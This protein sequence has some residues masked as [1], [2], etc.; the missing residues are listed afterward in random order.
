MQRARTSS[1]KKLS[2]A[3]FTAKAP[4]F[5]IVFR[6]LYFSTT[7]S[8]GKSFVLLITADSSAGPFVLFVGGRSIGEV[9]DPI[10]DRGA[11]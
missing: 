3:S 9:M 11:A 7:V 5:P 1:P 2:L 4:A 10:G 8:T 6:V